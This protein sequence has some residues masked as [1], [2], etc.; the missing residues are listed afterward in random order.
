MNLQLAYRLL[1]QKPRFSFRENPV[2]V[3]CA[4]VGEFNTFKPILKVLKKKFPILLTYFSPRAREYLESKR[5]LFDAIFPLPL[6]FPPLIRAFEERVSP[7]ALIVVE[8]ELW[9][10]LIKFSRTD[11]I[12]VNAYARGSLM[13]KLLVKNFSLI[14]ARTEKDRE[15][16]LKEGAKR[17]IV[18]GNLKLVPDE[19][20]NPQQILDTSKN[21]TVLVAGSTHRGEE[22]EILKA[23]KELKKDFRL[24]LILAPRH[25]SRADEV[26]KLVADFGFSVSR[27]S[28]GG[29][30]KEVLLL[31]TLGEL[32][33]FY[34]LADVAFVGGTLV[35]VGGHNV[36]EPAFFGKPVMFGPYIHKIHDIVSILKINQQGFL[37]KNWQ[38]LAKTTRKLLTETFTP[39][40]DL[41]K[42]AKRV[43]ECY[44]REIG[45]ALQSSL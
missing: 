25:V 36:L 33:G 21:Y 13:E 1:L 30:Y 5:E 8:R 31:D 11:K 37:V 27:R 15:V 40:E 18:C 4:S 26:H 22:E 12:L 42:I 23:F 2:W 45:R 43:K 3:H 44:L 34:A 29:D 35:P 38:D 41:R 16:F 32:R 39:K 17:V 20:T 7:R 24:K 9:I 28:E 6:D 10:S 19:D 14:I